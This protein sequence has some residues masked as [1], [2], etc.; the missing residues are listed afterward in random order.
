MTTY[1][2][3]CIDKTYTLVYF[4]HQGLSYATAGIPGSFE[5]ILNVDACCGRYYQGQSCCEQSPDVLLCAEMLIG[6]KNNKRLV[7]VTGR[8]D[9]V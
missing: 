8:Y 4:S 1:I 3:A 9:M 2:L 6:D 5:R 7:K